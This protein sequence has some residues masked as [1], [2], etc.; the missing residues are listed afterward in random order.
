MGLRYGP[1]MAR[2]VAPLFAA[3]F[4]LSLVGCGSD[5]ESSSSEPSGTP[6]TEVTVTD[7]T[8]TERTEPPV[9]EAATTDAPDSTEP[10]STTEPDQAAVEGIEVDD[11]PVCQ[12]F[13]NVF[14]ASFFQS[15]A[16]AFGGEEGAVE[17]IELYFAP[18]LAPEVVVIRTQGAPEF[19]ALPTLARVD[20]GIAA[21]T[22]GGFSDEELAEL[23]ASGG[24]SIA[25]VLA[26]IEPDLESVGPAPDAEAKLT[27]ATDAFL[28][29]VGTIDE[30]FAANADETAEAAFNEALSTQCPTLVASFGSL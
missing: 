24:D 19:Q 28:A 5:S 7:P 20:A 22:A 21:L 1:T 12:A 26:G 4:A 9:T 15:L 27:A 30:Y 16:G 25:S 10:A 29:D 3:A 8:V 14:A 6:T 17:K 18:A 11:V 23:A 13:A 2:F